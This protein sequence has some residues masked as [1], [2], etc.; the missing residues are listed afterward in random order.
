MVTALAR[1]LSNNVVICYFIL[2][3]LDVKKHTLPIVINAKQDL[4]PNKQKPDLVVPLRIHEQ[5]E[6]DHTTDKFPR[7]SKPNTQ[8]KYYYS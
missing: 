4:N 6:D 7:L 2:S 3:L 5:P 8:S 1:I